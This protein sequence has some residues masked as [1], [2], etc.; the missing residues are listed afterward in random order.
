M[1]HR[2]EKQLHDFCMGLFVVGM[3]GTIVHVALAELADQPFQ[4]SGNQIERRFQ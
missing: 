2:Y 4:H 3:I 1:I